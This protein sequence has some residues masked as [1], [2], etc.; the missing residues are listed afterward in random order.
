M[1]TESELLQILLFIIIK[2]VSMNEVTDGT[3]KR[4]SELISE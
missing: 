4:T 1:R 2:D 3:A